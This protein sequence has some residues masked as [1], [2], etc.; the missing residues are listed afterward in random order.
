MDKTKLQEAV[1]F[2]K[3]QASRGI[4]ATDL[5]NAFF[6]NGGKFAELFPSR[7]DREAFLQT[8]EYQ[9]IFQLRES[10]RAKERVAS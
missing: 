7:A 9:Q 8:D 5:H 4:S 10:L 6:G 3:A 1:E 2:V